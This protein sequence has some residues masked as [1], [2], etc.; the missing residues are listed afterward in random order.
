M[1][2]TVCFLFVCADMK[3]LRDDYVNTQ[4]KRSFGSSR[5]ES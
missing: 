5:A 3:R 1:C 4:F 2:F